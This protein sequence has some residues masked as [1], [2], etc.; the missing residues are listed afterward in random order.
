MFLRSEQA[1]LE[2]RPSPACVS[3]TVNLESQRGISV[4]HYESR[5]AML[6]F[7][8]GFG[9]TANLAS[10]QEKKPA[11]SQTAKS[12]EADER[13]RAEADKVSPDTPVITMA[14]ICDP[15]SATVNT[16]KTAC[17]TV[18]TRAEF[19]KFADAMD[20]D[21]DS[22]RGKSQFLAFYVKFS[23][24]ARE[25]QKQGLDKDPRFQRKL[26]L[27]RIQLLGQMLLQ[28]FQAKSTQ[29]APGEMQKFFRENPALFEQATLLRV[30]IPK[31]KF[32]DLPNGVQQPMPDSATEMKLAAQAIYSR[33]RT[34]TDFEALQK[35][36]SDTANFKEES[37]VKLEKMSRDHLRRSQQIV[38]DLKPGE[39]S[40]L[41]EEP[42]EGY[43]V[44]K[45]VS[46]EMPSFESVK[47]Q[48]GTALQKHRM[49]TWINN[50]TDSAKVSVNE[51][52]FGPNAWQ[53]AGKDH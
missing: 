44:F 49:D 5:L 42:N 48:I 17:R 25:A 35:E 51:E 33:A 22:Y 26:E 12:P 38:F 16:D 40:A 14:G 13:E 21:A 53:K 30:Y 29:F 8:V 43:Y 32:K 31:T 41:L 52:F 28:D 10:A 3:I 20:F 11:A 7:M 36:A 46:R 34:G 50:V 18:I 37:A 4:R 45:M 19:E 1:V 23:L 9:L 15:A 39:T 24:F 6:V 47:S 2:P 27:S